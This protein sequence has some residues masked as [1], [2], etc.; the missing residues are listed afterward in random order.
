GALGAGVASLAAPTI[1]ELTKDLPD[2]VKQ[3]V[4]AALASGLGAAVGGT[5]GAA[6]AFN[7]DTNNRQLHPDERILIRK[8]A[9]D[10]AQQVCG[11]DAQCLDSQTAYW[12][13][14]L[15]RVAESWV[16]DKEFSA[17]SQ[18]LTKLEQ[19][20]ANSGTEGH[21]TGAV[22]R[23]F[24][25]LQTAAGIL[26]TYQG[27]AISGT[28]QTYFSATPEQRA[29]YRLNYVLGSPPD[30]SIVPGMASRDE[31]RLDNMGV[32]NG[33]AQPVYP[34]EET[35]LGGMVTNRVAALL[36]RVGESVVGK[37]VTEGAAIA[38]GVGSKLPNV[39]KVV[40]DSRKIIDYALNPNNLS[41]GADKAKVFDSALGYNQSNAG[42]L[43]E[44][45]QTKLPSSEAIIGK[46]DQYGQRF[47]VDI[48]ITGPNG[49]TAIV[50]TGWILE[51]G[52]NVPRMTTL[53]VK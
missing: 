29:N 5:S 44:Q 38:E 21:V 48:P 22:D 50:R 33:S 12:A 14:A 8:L 17:N 34:V 4:G 36:G 49:N 6:T 16:D 7:A 51:P 30:T 45:I 9:K 15:E 10:K 19:I 23:Y 42:Q 2:G 13:D 35:V 52:S 46:L 1:D 37:G 28:D 32:M 11:S 18:Y 53:F 31:N 39:E 25:D 20:G 43:I 26:T 27:Q 24:A 3:A 41:G 40:V 47:T